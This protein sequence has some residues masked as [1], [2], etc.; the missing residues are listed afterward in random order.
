MNRKVILGVF[1]SLF[2][3]GTGFTVGPEWKLTSVQSPTAAGSSEP[4]WTSNADSIYLNWLEPLSEGG[5]SLRFSEWDGK[6][7]S[8]PLNVVS[9]IPF[10]L[11]WADFPSLL[12]MK[13]GTLVAHWL[14]KSGGSTYAYDV[15]IS[16]SN[17]NGQS[18][19]KPQIPHRD[20]VKNEHGFVSLLDRGPGHF[21]AVWLDSR[22]IKTGGHHHSEASGSMALMFADYQ[23]GSFQ[24]EI[25]LDPRVCD[26]CQT[27]AAVTRDGMFVAFRDRY[28]SEVRDI[29]YVRFTKGQWTNPKTLHADNWKITACPV[30]GPSVS[31]NGNNVVVAWFTAARNQAQVQVIF[32]ADA[33]KTFGKPVRIDQG[34]PNG[35]VDVRWIS[36]NNAVVSWLENTGKG[37]EIR[38]RTCRPDGTT[39]PY[40]TVAPSS[41]A[42]AS[43][44]PRIIPFGKEILIAWTQAGEPQ[45]IRIARL[46][47]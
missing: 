3:I 38:I 7:W 34:N 30:N 13:D 47:Q 44:F 24:P 23:N 33:G 9:G 18:W 27:G 10:F 11:N 16:V 8:S 29:S 46:S 39:D 41:A 17:D 32:S 35:R 31:A 15:L 20:G 26:C 4:N 36:Q 5:H 22:N 21:S 19:S 37:G 14:Q 42:R 2:L 28:D 1:A 12:K 40:F 25:T 6:N 43:G 45:Q